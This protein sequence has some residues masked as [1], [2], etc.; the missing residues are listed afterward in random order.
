MPGATATGAGGTSISTSIETPTL[1]EISTATKPSRNYRN[2]DSS[3]KRVRGSGSTTLNTAKA[4]PIAT[5]ERRKS[6]TARAPTMQLGH[7]NNFV[8][9]LNK[10][11]K[12]SAAVASAIAAVLARRAGSETVAV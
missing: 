9:G 3:I 4:F 10:G 2:G 1:I 8:D 12:I 7:A 6:L 11:D 5:K